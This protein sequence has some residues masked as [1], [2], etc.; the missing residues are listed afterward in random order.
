MRVATGCL[1]AAAAIAVTVSPRAQTS[2]STSVSFT[3]VEASIAD[4]RAAMEKK[5][6]TSRQIVTQS[7]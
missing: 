4:M 2:T 6:V 7:L 1:V 5:R 3:V